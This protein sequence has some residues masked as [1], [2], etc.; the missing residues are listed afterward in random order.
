MM[1]TVLPGFSYRVGG[2]WD[3]G[4]E[5]RSLPGNLHSFGVRLPNYYLGYV[6]VTGR[7]EHWTEP[8]GFSMSRKGIYFRYRQL[9][10]HAEPHYQREDR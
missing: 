4:I 9:E 5:K 7:Y 6:W 2:P 8:E 10:L 3:T 1:L